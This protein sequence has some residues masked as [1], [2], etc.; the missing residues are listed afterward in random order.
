[1][2]KTSNSSILSALLENNNKIENEKNILRK[3]YN[4]NKYLKEFINKGFRN[5]L[6]VFNY[7]KEENIKLIFIYENQIKIFNYLTENSKDK[8]N[9]NI[10]I[11]EEINLLEIKPYKNIFIELYQNVFVLCRLINRTLLIFSE[12]QKYYIEW[13][14]IITAIELLSYSKISTN[15]NNDIYFNEIII[16]DEDGYLT[17]IE[18]FIEYFDKKKEFKIKSL[19]NNFRRNKVHYSY[20]NGIIY[21]KR[22]NIIISSCGKGYI[23]INNG[24]SFDILNI[25]K[26]DKNLN[27][28]DYKISEYDLLYI[29]TNKYINNKCIYE[30]YCYTLNG[31]KIKKLDIKKEIN[32]FYNNNKSI[33]IVYRDGNIREYDCATFEEKELNINTEELKDIKNFG[34]VYHSVFFLKMSTIFIIFNNQFKNI[35][36]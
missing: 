7:N 28:L 29:Y 31:I 20:I 12:K 17:K 34:D 5:L 24:Y 15:L 8:P 19:N 27:I 32:N 4:I 2:K 21:S 16:G 25:I 36:I 33:Y 13:P 26:I 35:Q 14:C 18:V 10:D 6:Y 11:D 1:M 23:T 9:I 30:L 3:K 22:L